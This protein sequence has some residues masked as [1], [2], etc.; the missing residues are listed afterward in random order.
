M[1][2]RNA[3]ILSAFLLCIVGAAQAAPIDVRYDI[4]TYSSGGFSASW[5][6][7]AT[8]CAAEGPDSHDTLYMC[9]D[10][11]VPVTGHIAGSLDNDVLTIEGGSLF[12]FGKN[13]EVFG[14]SLGSDFVNAT[15][16][17]LW[18]LQVEY[19]GTF[20]FENI[21]MGPGGPNSFDGHE[22]VLWGQ[23]DDAYGCAP[24]ADTKSY[25]TA[26]GIDLYAQR[27]SEPGALTLLSIAAI[28]TL[29]LR[30]RRRRTIPLPN[31]K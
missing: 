18:Y 4:Q 31:V 7:S 13:Y 8:G 14:G 6:H 20:F 17:L 2:R 30:S 1:I 24:D 23:N 22:F 15:G 9:G 16:D 25:C 21:A 28:L 10:F 27:V 11:S 19:F 29:S 5:I 3:K 12:V 26:F